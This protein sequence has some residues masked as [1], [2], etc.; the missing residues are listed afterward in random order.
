MLP[1]SMIDLAMSSSLLV[2]TIDA[3]IAKIPDNQFG[4]VFAG[5]VMVMLGGVLSAVVVGTILEKKNLYANVVADSYIQ[6]SDGDDEEKFWKGLSDEE[7]KKAREI[8]QRIKENN[9]NPS[10]VAAAVTTTPATADLIQ[11]PTSPSLP[12][13]ISASETGETHDRQLVAAASSTSDADSKKA[14]F[15]DY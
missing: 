13:T 9:N 4:L 1:E 8:L 14:M 6:Q 3:D 15:S 2:A 12:T 10:G 5:G 7:Q 11:S